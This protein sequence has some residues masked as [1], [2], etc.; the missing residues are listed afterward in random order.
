ME[1]W[2]L[3]M[4]DPTSIKQEEDVEGR[5]VSWCPEPRCYPRGPRTVESR[6]GRKM[7]EDGCPAMDHCQ[8]M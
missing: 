7:Y 4:L 3:Q 8:T 6:M 2:W 1:D 5:H